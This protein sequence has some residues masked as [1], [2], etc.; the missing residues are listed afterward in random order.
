MNFFA[1]NS[2]NNDFS[3]QDLSYHDLSNYNLSHNLFIGT[4]LNGCNLS[5]SN[6]NGANLK[7]TQ[8]CGADLTG[9]SLCGAKLHHAKLNGANLCQANLAGANL[10]GSDLRY[11]TLKK[12]K[13]NDTIFN[14][15][16]VE[17]AVFESCDGLTED[18]KRTLKNRGAIFKDSISEA[19]N[20][21]WYIQYV[22]VP[23]LVALIG[24]GVF[25]KPQNDTC[26]LSWDQKS[27][28][29]YL[30]DAGH[31]MEA[32]QTNEDVYLVANLNKPV[33]KYN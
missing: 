4:K 18:I 20:I 6:L 30:P 9:A 23:I 1:N 19:G 27:I 14:D 33:L 13:L 5:Y 8:L 2:S 21:R 15:V 31:N 7:N 22:A 12:V 10:T 25:L 32:P 17:N 29:K 16:K 26:S 11:A 28:L 24:A 3:Q